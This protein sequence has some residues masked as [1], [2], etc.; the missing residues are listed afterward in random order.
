MTTSPALSQLSALPRSRSP[1]IGRD[2]EL[3]GVRDLLLRDDV[4]LLTLTGPGGVGKTHLAL[5]AA[6][7]AAHGFGDGVTFVPLAPINDP[8]LVPSAIAHALGVREAGDEPLV[9]RLKAVL[10]DKNLL[11]V[12][13]NFEQVVTAAPLVVDMLDNSPGL[14]V[15]VTS[16]VRLRL[17]GEREHVVPPLGLAGQ[18]QDTFE[19]SAASEAVRLFVARA[20]AVAEDFALTPENAS[21]VLAICRRL[22]GL[23]LAIELAAARIKVLPPTA[24]LSRLDQRLPLLTGGGR[25]LPARQQTMREAIAWSYALLTPE[26]Q[27]FFRR[28]AVFAGGFTIEAVEA[29]AGSHDD[30]EGDVLDMIGA[31]VEASL[32]RVEPVADE[33]RFGM[34]ETIREFGLEKL[35]ANGEEDASWERHAAWYLKLA[36]FIQPGTAM[37][38]ATTLFGRLAD[39]QQNI[40][41]ALAWFAARGDGE[42]LAQLAGALTFFWWIS[43][44][45]R[46]GREWQDLALAAGRVSDGAR[47]A[48]LA[49]AGVLAN[50]LGEHQTATAFAVELQG[51]ARRARDQ[52]REANALFLLSRAANQRGDHTA[53]KTLA[54]ETVALYEELIDPGWLPWAQ[55]RLGIEMYLTGDIP[56]AANLFTEALHGFRAVENR[57]GAAYALT[58]LGLAQHALGNSEEARATYQEGLVEHRYGGDRLETAG[59]LEQIAALILESGADEAAVQLLGAAAAMY[60]ITGTQPHPY[61]WD[62]HVRAEAEARS[63]L[64]AETYAH[65]WDAGSALSFT[66]AI[67]EA[68]KILTAA[69]ASPPAAIPVPG[70]FEDRLTAREQEVLRLLVSGRSNPEIA[71]ALFISRATARTHVGNILAKLG[72]RSRT[73]AADV[74]HRQNLI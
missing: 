30:P 21:V 45:P 49:G 61:L 51:L 73:E 22:D 68:L 57:I 39:D 69:E 62:I 58:N 37:T 12:L 46:E 1:L 50:Q 70:S 16:R 23:P 31:L 24:L 25:D 6:A 15:L 59:L 64:D 29:V 67:E 14:R 55:Q 3:T 20:Q 72:V 43:G 63:R 33:P 66:E 40:R 42:S 54:E 32:V 26:Q 28:L 60:Q 2:R 10:R 4:S 53:A 56:Q 5:S 27:A 36:T 48:L 19:D 11:L 8:A 44:Q 74:A 71:E 47:M 35:A 41:A 9:D 38:D 13:D 17:S 18:D 52:A 34:L 7:A 65:A